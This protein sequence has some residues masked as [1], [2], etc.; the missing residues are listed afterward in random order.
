M[1][2]NVADSKAKGSENL[3]LGVAR[4]TSPF[5]AVPGT[6]RQRRRRSRWA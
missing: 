1:R 3:N 5:A 6:M 4:T 2:M